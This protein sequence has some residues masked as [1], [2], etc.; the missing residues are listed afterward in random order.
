MRSIDTIDNSGV[1]GLAKE[2]LLT[3][4]GLILAIVYGSSVAGTSRIDSDVDIAVLFDNPL[5]A[6]Q[7]MAMATRLEKNLSRPVDLVDLCILNG[8]ILKQILCNGRVLVRKDIIPPYSC[9]E[10]IHKMIYNQAD[11]MPYVTRTLMERQQRFI[12]G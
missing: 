2:I 7:K 1:M 11:M 5:T 12:N 6:D 10:L 9:Y 3:E 8:T 4:A